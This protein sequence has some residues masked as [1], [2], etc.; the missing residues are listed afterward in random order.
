MII[1]F[2]LGRP[3]ANGY[4]TGHPVVFL[5]EFLTIIIFQILLDVKNSNPALDH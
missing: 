2:I 4:Y 5:N 3:L 1:N